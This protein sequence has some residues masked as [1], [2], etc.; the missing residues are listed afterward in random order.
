L[1]QLFIEAVT[2]SILN[3]KTKN[4]KITLNNYVIHILYLL[5]FHLQ[6]DE[7]IKKKTIQLG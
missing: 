1:S 4:A 3:L 2:Q 5:L 6:L 7:I